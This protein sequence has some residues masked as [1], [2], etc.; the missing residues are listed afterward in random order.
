[1]QDVEELKASVAQ[2]ANALE[3][4]MRTVGD[5][6]LQQGRQ[7]NATIEVVLEVQRDAFA[8]ERLASA[9]AIHLALTHPDPVKAVQGLREMALDPLTVDDEGSTDA[10]RAPLERVLAKIEAAILSQRKRS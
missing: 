4:G 10:M 3:R 6:L 7:I 2:L 5:Q 8:S 1:M 9:C